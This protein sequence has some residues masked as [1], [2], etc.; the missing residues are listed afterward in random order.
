FRQREYLHPRPNRNLR[1]DPQKLFTVPPGV[2][3]DAANHALLIQQV[4]GERWDRTHVDSTENQSTAFAQGFQRCRY[5]LSR[6]SKHNR[7]VEL[8]WRRLQRS[9][10]PFWSQVHSQFLVS[11]IAS[12]R[13][14]FDPPMPR[15]LNR[16][17]CRRPEAVKP[18]ILSR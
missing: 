5:N 14:H 15:H 11:L 3:S 18:Q 7:R 13:I 2:V 12:R 17:V 6:W 16:D 9:A 8:L 1:R 4:V 10:R